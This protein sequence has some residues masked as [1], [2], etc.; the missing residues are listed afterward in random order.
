EVPWINPAIEPGREYKVLT[1][2]PG[3]TGVV[4][5]LDRE[6]GAFLWARPTV[7]QTVL[8]SIDG[9]SGKAT[10]N[11]AMLFSESGQSIEVCPST[12]GGKN[13]WAGAYSPRSKRMFY[14]LQ[15]TCSDMA[16]TSEEANAEELYGIFGREKLAPGETMLGTVQAISAESGQRAWKA[17]T[18]GTSL[19][20][21]ATGGGL[22]FGGDIEGSFRAYDED[23]GE[24]LWQVELGSA[25]TGYPV[26]FAVDGRQY[27]AVGTGSS[28][29]TNGQQRLM[30]EG[31]QLGSENRLHVFALPQ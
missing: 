22:V 25:V 17:E 10:V 15:N 1:G 11:P 29:T 14:A 4:Y 7:R 8:A 27:I 21:V 16:V 12:G 5:T 18:R 30:P 9:T 19:S 28:V 6:S 3:K 31:F 2:I 24:V 13:W 20:L 26:S 23:S